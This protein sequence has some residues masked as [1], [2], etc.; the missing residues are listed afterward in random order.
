M[1]ARFD[2]TLPA[3]ALLGQG[4]S[5]SAD[6][7]SCPK[8]TEQMASMPLPQV[9]MSG[10]GGEGAAQ[11]TRRLGAAGIPSERIMFCDY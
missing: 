1:Q 8:Q 4:L 2:V 7:A 9:L 10:L 3:T 6:A 5:T 11:L